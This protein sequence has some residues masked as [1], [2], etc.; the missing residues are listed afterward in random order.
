MARQRLR[1]VYDGSVLQEMLQH[2]SPGLKMFVEENLYK[3]SVPSG[4]VG[5]YATIT[6]TNGA[7]ALT[8]AQSWAE[9]LV[10]AAGATG[11]VTITSTQPF[12]AGAR[13]LVR[14][15]TNQT[16]TFKWAGDATGVTIATLTSVDV[17][18][19]GTI[20]IAGLVGT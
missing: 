12:S 17:R 1:F 20:A 8:D 16:I 11:A 3:A 15:E 19:N 7:N 18:C 4:A 5:G 10:C 6:P 14:N 13:Q 9:Y 2:L